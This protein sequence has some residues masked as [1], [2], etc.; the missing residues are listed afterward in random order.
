MCGRYAL[1]IRAS[2]VRYQLQQQG[3]PVDDAPQDD[4]ARETYNF[5]PGA[6]GLVYRA[7]VPDHGIRDGNEAEA[8]DDAAQADQTMQD[9]AE[10]PSSQPDS[11]KYEIK[12]MK[13]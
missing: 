6:Y 7:E 5:P 1:G 12:V 9:H 11:Y 10:P 8:N 4:E 13:W 2:F 3:L